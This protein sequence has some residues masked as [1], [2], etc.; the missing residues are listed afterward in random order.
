MIP[1]ITY[2]Y[3]RNTI[4]CQ[5]GQ[6]SPTM[7]VVGQPIKW[8]PTHTCTDTSL[9]QLD[10]LVYPYWLK[11]CFTDWRYTEKRRYTGI[12]ML[13]GIPEQGRAGG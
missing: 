8:V 6:G 9:L 5:P 3:R 2:I 12:Q 11:R 1:G 7:K 10:D 4:V 13:G